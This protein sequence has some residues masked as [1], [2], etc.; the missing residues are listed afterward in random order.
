MKTINPDGYRTGLPE[1][2]TPRNDKRVFLV[3]LAPRSVHLL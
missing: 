3:T 2:I 1:R